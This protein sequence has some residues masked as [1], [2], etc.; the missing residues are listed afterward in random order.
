[1]IRQ[2]LLLRKLGPYSSTAGATATLP[3][4]G[5]GPIALR[6]PDRPR[7][8]HRRCH[9]DAVLGM[10]TAIRPVVHQPEA[11]LAQEVGNLASRDDGGAVGWRRQR[12]E[13]PSCLAPRRQQ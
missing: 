4:A 1:M 3:F 11:V 12:Q 13:Q 5:L 6:Q 2:G 10:V 9:A 7:V 8:I